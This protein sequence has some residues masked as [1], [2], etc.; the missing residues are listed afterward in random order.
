MKKYARGVRAGE[1]P[2]AG[3]RTAETAGGATYLADALAYLECEVQ[4]RHPA[5]DH[6]LVVGRVV[7]GRLLDPRAAPMLYAET[8]DMD[9][10]SA[11]FG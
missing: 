8:G 10:S 3:M 9:G 5:G 7:G 1:D 2:F 4:D 6:E 11:L